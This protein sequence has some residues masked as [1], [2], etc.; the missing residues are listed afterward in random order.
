LLVAKP[1]QIPLNPPFS[2]G[3]DKLGAPFSEGEDKQAGF[4]DG[5]MAISG[6]ERT[7]IAQPSGTP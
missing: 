4:R 3:E 5:D 2:K 1:K 7:K 6:S